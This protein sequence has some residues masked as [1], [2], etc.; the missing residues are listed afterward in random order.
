MN[1]RTV[2]TVQTV[3]TAKTAKTDGGTLIVF[4]TRIG[5]FFVPTRGARVRTFKTKR[6]LEWAATRWI[7]EGR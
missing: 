4:G 1:N 6:G 5:G 7:A 3:Q 2:Q